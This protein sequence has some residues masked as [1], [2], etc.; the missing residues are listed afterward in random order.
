M[1]L[2]QSSSLYGYFN[3]NRHR[4]T[5]ICKCKNKEEKYRD[6]DGIL[7]IVEKSNISFSSRSLHLMYYTDGAVLKITLAR[8]NSSNV[9]F[10]ILSILRFTLFTI[11]HLINGQVSRSRQR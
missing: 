5:Y 8:D 9:D 4:I 11:M 7:D 6:R 2:I 10:S 3:N 1:T